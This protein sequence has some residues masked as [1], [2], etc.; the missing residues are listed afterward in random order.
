M[1][2]GWDNL[3]TPFSDKEGLH[4]CQR[5]EP[6]CHSFVMT[7]DDHD[8]LRFFFLHFCC[9]LDENRK[10]RKKNRSFTSSAGGFKRRPSLAEG[11]SRPV[12]RALALRPLEGPR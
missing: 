12:G 5:V 7:D 8:T 6:G 9:F 4:G 10:G 3:Y 11:G 2:H 1:G